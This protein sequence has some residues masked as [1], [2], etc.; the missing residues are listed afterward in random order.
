MFNSHGVIVSLSFFNINSTFL[1]DR[2]IVFLAIR[3]ILFLKFLE[4]LEKY[5][6]DMSFQIRLECLIELLFHLNI[7][8]FL[9][10]S[11][12]GFASFLLYYS[13]FFHLFVENLHKRKYLIFLFVDI[14]LLFVYFCSFC[15]TVLIWLLFIS[16]MIL[17]SKFIVAPVAL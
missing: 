16:R 13:N 15:F 4:V 2:K 9:L 12:G 14:D 11:L 8:V 10:I 3:C 5:C 17:F 1:F 7:D 6:L